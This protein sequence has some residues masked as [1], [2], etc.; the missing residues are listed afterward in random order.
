M[1]TTS[2]YGINLPV[3]GDSMANVATGFNNAWPVITNA[4]K[5]AGSGSGALPQTGYTVNQIFYSTTW[6]SAFILLAIDANWGYIWR[7]IHARW[8]PWQTVGS[9]ILSDTTNYGVSSEWTPMYRISNSGEFQLAGGIKATFVVTFPN[10]ALSILNS[11]PLNVRPDKAMQWS[12]PMHKTGMGN[13]NG[14]YFWKLA[15]STAGVW[16]STVFNNA[17]GVSDADTVFFWPVRFQIANRT[18]L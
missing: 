18:D 1:A 16:S 9:A 11:L 12:L 17:S 5:V 13:N 3:P 15:L 8:G 14:N 6:K 2:H 4:P 7:P 10:G